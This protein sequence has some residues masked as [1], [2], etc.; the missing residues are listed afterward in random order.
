[1]K[2]MCRR[3]MRMRSIL[4]TTVLVSFSVMARLRRSCVTIPGFN[5]ALRN[6]GAGSCQGYSCSGGLPS[7]AVH[8]PATFVNFTGLF[9]AIL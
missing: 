9:P 4:F 8:R 2:M 6:P 3:T 7:A 5:T 1:M